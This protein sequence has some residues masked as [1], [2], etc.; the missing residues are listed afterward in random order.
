MLAA[1][2]VKTVE[3]LRHFLLL[4]LQQL[5]RPLANYQLPQNA[6]L[7]H[8]NFYLFLVTQEPEVAA[9]VRQDYISTMSKLY[10]SYF[11]S[12]ATR[13]LKLVE[14]NGVTK[15]D[16][17]GAEDSS[18]GAAAAA[19]ARSLF[20]RAAPAA[21]SSSSKS[22][23]FTLGTYI[24]IIHPIIIQFTVFST[25]FTKFPLNCSMF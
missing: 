1:L 14:A 9:E 5:R 22:T 25:Q 21:R 24:F 15:E 2:Q 13:L 3:R 12:Y 16:V 7:K 18:L 19:A 11:K 8:K 20:G 6:L 4:K 10:Y 23:I 17:L